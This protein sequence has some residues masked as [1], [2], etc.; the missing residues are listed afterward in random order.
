LEVKVSVLGAYFRF[1]KWYS[2]TDGTAMNGNTNQ[3]ENIKISKP[4]YIHL[5]FFLWKTQKPEKGIAIFRW[6]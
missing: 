2:I 5:Q 1:S 6:A 3:I 4:Y